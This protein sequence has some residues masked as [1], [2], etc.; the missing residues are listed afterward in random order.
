MPATGDERSESGIELK[1]LYAADDAPHP[2][3]APGEYPFFCSTPGHAVD[4][5]GI[6]RV[7]KFTDSEG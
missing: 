6:M 7:T 2:L 4:M 3:E 1:P 5:N